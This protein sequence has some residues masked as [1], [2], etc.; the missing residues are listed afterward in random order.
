MQERI[1]REGAEGVRGAGGAEEVWDVEVGQD[2]QEELGG[3]EAEGWLGR[4]H[5]FLC[6]RLRWMVWGVD[7]LI[8]CAW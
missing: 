8:R 4:G 6:V 1:E 3:E 2:V 7:E 5:C